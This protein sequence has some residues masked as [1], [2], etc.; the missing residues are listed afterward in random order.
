M[1]AVLGVV[2]ER[3]GGFPETAP[4]KLRPPTAARVQATPSPLPPSNQTW[5]RSYRVQDSPRNVATELWRTS[6][7][8]MRSTVR[9][10]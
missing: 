1:M 5:R 4:T 3:H 2:F 6:R 9:R 7:S 8:P 10:Q